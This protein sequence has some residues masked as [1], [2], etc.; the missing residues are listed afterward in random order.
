M[1][2]KFIVGLDL[3]LIEKVLET[4]PFCVFRYKNRIFCASFLHN[5]ECIKMRSYSKKKTCNIS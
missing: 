1:R 5:L 3:Q 2:D 4:V